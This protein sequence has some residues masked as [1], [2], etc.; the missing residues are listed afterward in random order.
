M[1]IGR[2]LGA[3]STAP[4]S[5]GGSRRGMALLMVLL[6]LSFLLALALPFLLS[7]TSEGAAARRRLSAAKARRV[8]AS[9]RDA[10][11][12]RAS[13]SDP[14]VDSF[15]S[16]GLSSLVDTRDEVVRWEPGTKEEADQLALAGEN[17]GGETW[18]AQSRICAE[19]AG[20]LV[21]ANI[22]GWSA[23]I[24]ESVE[25][26][27]VEIPV[28][29]TKGF[30]DSGYLWIMGEL[31]H[32][33]S[34]SATAFLQCRRGVGYDEAAGTVD[35][36]GPP[37][38]YSMGIPVLDVRAW[39]LAVSPV[40]R[41]GRKE[42]L[43]WTSFEEMKEI[44]KEG[45]GPLPPEKLARLETFMTLRSSRRFSPAWVY[46][47]AL[48][49]AETMKNGRPV[50]FVPS[51]RYFNTGSLVRIR[52]GAG[53]VEYGVV[54]GSGRAGGGRVQ[55]LSS[56]GTLVLE[57][58][59]L[60]DWQE[61]EGTVEVLAPVPVNL[62]T[63][64]EEVLAVL[65]TY[66]RDRRRLQSLRRG[67]GAGA[68]QGAVR[69]WVSPSEAR[70]L[71]KTL[72]AMRGSGGGYT[73]SGD[74]VGPF[75]DPKDLV[76]RVFRKL[77][78]RDASMSFNP[79]LMAALYKNVLNSLDRGVTLGTLPLCFWSGPV[80][81]YR[82][83][84][85]I[86]NPAGGEW[87]RWEKRGL[88][89][90]RPE[91]FPLEV[92]W[93]TQADFDEALR[94]SRGAR[95]WITL[96]NNTSFYDGRNDPPS[97]F[98]P[99]TWPYMAVRS[100]QDTDFD[101]GAYYP[102]D[103]E[104]SSR[105]RPEPVRL[106]YGGR[107]RTL[108]RFFDK[109]PDPEG[110]DLGRRPFL[111]D[112]F[113]SGG[114]RGGGGAARAGGMA[115]PFHAS[116]WFKPSRGG[117]MTLMDIGG[118]RADKDR[119][120][121]YLNGSELVLEV[122]DRAGL[123]PEPGMY[124][125]RR[126]A[127][128]VRMPLAEYPVRPGVWTHFQVQ[129]LGNSPDRMSLFVDGVPRGRHDYMTRLVSQIP[130]YDHKDETERY[131]QIQVE[132]ARGF[133][134]QGVLRIG[135]ELFEYTSLKG[136]SFSCKRM[137]STGGRDAR[138]SAWEWG[139]Q[140]DKKLPGA[141]NLPVPAPEHQPGEA[142]VLYGYSAPLQEFATIPPVELKLPSEIGPWRI[143]RMI[144]KK[145]EIAVGR[146]TLG[147]G[148][149]K[150]YQGDLELGPP[151]PDA[152]KKGGSDK[153][154]MGGF[155]KEGGYALL[156]QR[157]LVVQGPPQGGGG[158]GGGGGQGSFETKVVGGV[159][160][161]HY[162]SVSGNKLRGVRLGG[163]LPDLKAG[164][165]DVGA[166]NLFRGT[167]GLPT[168]FDGQ[169][170]A[171]VGQ[172]A[173]KEMEARPSNWA[174]VIPVSL[175]V[176]GQVGLLPNPADTGNSEY[177]Q[178]LPKNVQADT[179][180]VRYDALLQD[181]LIRDRP[182][183]VA[184]LLGRLGTY[185][186]QL[187]Q[188]TSWPPPYIRDPNFK[189]IK[190]GRSDEIGHI[191]SEI[192]PVDYW[193]GRA[194]R[195]RGPPETGTSTHAQGPDALVLP[196]FRVRNR[197]GPA[198]SFYGRPGRKDRVALV[199]GSRTAGAVGSSSGPLVEWHTVNWTSRID[200]YDKDDPA[201]PSP[202][203]PSIFVAF[204]EGVKGVFSQ[205][206]MGIGGRG[207][208]ASRSR[209]SGGGRLR[210][211]GSR[212]DIRQWTRLVKFPSGEMPWRFQGKLQFGMPQCSDGWPADG[213]LDMVTAGIPAGTVGD[214]GG[215]LMLAFPTPEKGGGEITLH[216]RL[217]F[218]GE[219][220]GVSS[221]LGNVLFKNGGLLQVGEEVMAY[222]EA[223]QNGVVR[224]AENGRGLLGTIP[225]VH[226]MWET[227]TIL[228]RP[229]ATVLSQGV[230]AGSPLL[231]VA[232]ADRLPVDRGLV[233]VDHE[234]IHYVYSRRYLSLEMPPR[235]APARKGRTTSDSEFR[236]GDGI[237]RGRFGTIPASH[238]A[239]TAVIEFPFRYWDTYAERADAPEMH[240]LD[241]H[242]ESPRAVFK[243]VTWEE[244]SPE[245]L[246]DLQLLAR[247]D[248]RTP[249]WEKPAPG[250]GLF[251]FDAP[252]Y[253]DEPRKI[254]MQ[255]KVLDLRL[256]TVYKPGAFDP[257]N[258]LSQAWKT[259]PTLKSVKVVYEAPTV[260]LREEE[261]SW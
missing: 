228:T 242:L 8:S 125:P 131:I 241:L 173:T 128:A 23:M 255:G 49:R 193:C 166:R 113:G 221:N 222:K 122:L 184:R 71:A 42:W 154:F 115:R 108:S 109:E 236:R 170:R 75:K 52:G 249:W 56:S 44:E 82:A 130:P 225:T 58:G 203:H 40:T 234:L 117:S 257:V 103:K 31:V 97:R 223:G 91:G 45:H 88:A 102:S 235:R 209:S 172:W 47:Q 227:V 89:F 144:N 212:F 99:H 229:G 211:A 188:T 137:D 24:T 112:L 159:V 205:G 29:S 77:F 189:D 12:R 90:V 69:D 1:K 119:V 110:R 55:V 104:E 85:S 124:G 129:I 216:T 41:S 218:P 67:G 94:I 107:S 13:A 243:T 136:N 239:G 164:S 195:F 72:A 2:N 261:G 16:K 19:G 80:V 11:L 191:D 123:D 150:D 132:D 151:A 17:L 149:E 111:W 48:L 174:Y 183:A 27:A 74:G 219:M 178:I 116:F 237:F 120:H 106:F 65:F 96:P 250:K 21:Y 185:N 121:L 210:R 157:M 232:R 245:A 231:P 127:G 20:P 201:I 133:P 66:L 214:V 63:A 26:D 101:A 196:V 61:Y 143:A 230:D 6:V 140:S 171:F 248:A 206:S 46:P 155:Q 244:E 167:P 62:N 84:V 50:L 14:S 142:V 59:L 145:D 32:Y 226:G 126:T 260:V 138:H 252:T 134:P 238:S 81:G 207:K 98:Q 53:K 179:E 162:S 57:Q 215:V 204:M 39:H 240:H 54:L 197:W 135:S 3:P 95:G 30:D 7:V 177:V 176:Q 10:L 146:R 246:V 220:I 76:D 247:V 194:F 258:F 153:S 251:L 43:P 73:T 217:V 92:V 152:A 181:M 68:M 158:G 79:L 259:A 114:R 168:F 15:P 18:D 147:K 200:G 148:I 192:L 64:S 160:V 25:S 34:K 28:D 38:K 163:F 208:G 198:A 139:P 105:A 182:K 93:T 213:L 186:A 141:T 199:E 100:A 180:W 86:L 156:V 253:K 224:L 118:G 35:R 165:L 37:R 22:L 254:G 169:M 78:G 4:F 36:W 70:D 190:P 9:L 83:G 51:A 161:V 5:T 187:A 87:A 33:G 60:G 233:L 202:R 256:F 175:K